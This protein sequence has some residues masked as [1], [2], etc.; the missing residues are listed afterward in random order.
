[1]Q[2][3]KNNGC[4]PSATSFSGSD[5]REP[6]EGATTGSALTSRL[7]AFASTERRRAALR[8]GASEFVEGEAVESDEDHGG[9][10]FG[11]GLGSARR[12]GGGDD[13]IGGEDGD[14]PDRTVEGEADEND[15]DDGGA[16]FGLG[17]GAARRAGGS[18][19]D[20]SGGEDGDGPDR[21]VEGLVDDAAMDAETE[22]NGCWP[23]ATLFSDSDGRE[24]KEGVATGTASFSGSDGR[25]PRVGAA[26]GATP[27]SRLEAFPEASRSSSS[28]SLVSFE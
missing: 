12:A 7:V 1:M 5:G 14:G 17:L 20:E 15:E 21:I 23:G 3:G 8:Y 25:D 26:T 18:N 16:G 22:A 10:E 9:A 19:N 13:E 4:W 11:F 28:L 24:P 27:T 6:R 2:K